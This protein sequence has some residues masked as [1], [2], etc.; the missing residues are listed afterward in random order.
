VHRKKTIPNGRAEIMKIAILAYY[1]PP[2]RRAGTELATFYLAKHLQARG[3]EVHVITSR[4]PGLPKEERYE[5]VIVHRLYWPNSS[6]LGRAILQLGMCLAIRRINPQIIHFQSFLVSTCAILVKRTWKKPYVVAGQ[7]SEIYLLGS[8]RPRTSFFLK[9][10]LR[11]VVRNACAA[12]ALTEDMGRRILHDY[13]RAAAVI[14]NGVEVER[15]GRRISKEEARKKFQLASDSRIIVF[16]GNLRPVK[17]VA[18]LIQALALI[19]E[20]DPNIVLL[21][22][23]GVVAGEEEGE[24]TR[25]N[26]LVEELNLKENVIFVGSVPNQAVPEYLAASDIFASPSLSEGF[27]VSFLEAMAASLPIVA[28]NVTGISSIVKEG[29][30]AFLVEPRNAAQIADKV[31]ILL[32]DPEL[33]HRMSENNR[34]LVQKYAWESV[35][36]DLEPI[37]LRCLKSQD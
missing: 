32:N 18:Y 30:N 17:G 2:K 3:N 6:V 15:F 10:I 34:V 33:L 29:V 28:T 4:D 25:L 26:A 7:G 12:I 21:V 11:V 1:F 31:T 5:G 16:V 22:V 13:G 14:P 9:V 35:A 19:R 8:V 37:Y 36:K 27:P 23:G 24:G 20:R